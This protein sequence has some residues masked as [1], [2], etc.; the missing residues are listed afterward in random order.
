LIL[1]SIVTLPFSHV[2]ERED[3]PISTF[4]VLSFL[5]GRKHHVMDAINPDGRYSPDRIGFSSDV[6]CQPVHFEGQ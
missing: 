5:S 3:L 6:I 4:L 1:F 2:F